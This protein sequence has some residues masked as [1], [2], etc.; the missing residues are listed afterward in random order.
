MAHDLL[1]GPRN[2]AFPTLLDMW[3]TFIMAYENVVSNNKKQPET[4]PG[5]DGQ[6]RKFKSYHYQTLT[7][8]YLDTLEKTVPAS[9]VFQGEKLL[10]FEVKIFVQ[11]VLADLT[12]FLDNDYD[13]L[14]SHLQPFWSSENE[15]GKII[16]ETKYKSPMIKAKRLK[17]VNL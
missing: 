7:C 16:L 15:E 17:I 4:K 12:E 14:D 3:P 5:V 9:K 6:L 1:V 13:D 2:E 10:P 8:L 11:T